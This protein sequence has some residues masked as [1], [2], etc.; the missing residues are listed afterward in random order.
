M[1][2]SIPSQLW[3]LSAQRQ[4]TIWVFLL[5][6]AALSLWFT[7]RPGLWVADPVELR[8]SD[9]AD[10]TYLIDPNTASWASLARL[11]QVGRS[12]ARKLVAHRQKRRG[13]GNEATVVFARL[14][15]LAE[16]KGFGA[17][18]LDAIAPYLVF[19]LEGD[20]SIGQ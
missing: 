19:P 1:H 10:G 16:V 20:R 7:F 9:I 6:V 14:E 17:G 8:P 13:A 4:R 15:D 11:P 12:K 3:G 2:R 5:L 18:T